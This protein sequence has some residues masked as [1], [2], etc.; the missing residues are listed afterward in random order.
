MMEKIIA[1]MMLLFPVVC[2]SQE[3]A[4]YLI[5]NDIGE[6]R[7]RPKRTTETY[8]NSGVLISADHFDLD[9]NDIT[10]SARYVHPV[11]ILGVE[12]QVTRHTDSLDALKWLLHELDIEFRN[13]Y[14]IPEYYLKII[15]GNTIYIWSRRK[16]LSLVER[17]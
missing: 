15:D 11:T 14:G 16:R 6:Y 5:L 7:Y 4:N 8:G 1:L 2:F 10:Y 13:Y 3:T 9:H 17:E 12:V